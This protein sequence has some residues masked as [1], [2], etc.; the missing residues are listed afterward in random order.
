MQDEP[1][2]DEFVR[3]V[4]DFLRTDIAP[5]LSGHAA[6]KL[7]VA[8]NMLDLVERQLTLAATSDA[9]ETRRLAALLG[10]DG[11]LEDQNRELAQRIASGDMDQRTPG[12]IDHLWQTTLDK[13]AIDQPTYASYRRETGQD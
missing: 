13:L 11:A 6:F 7:R 2:P 8:C 1:R 10:H 4:A 5:Q 9:A 12:L 3:S